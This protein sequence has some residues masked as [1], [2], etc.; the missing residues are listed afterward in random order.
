MQDVPQRKI[1]RY[2][3]QEELGRGAMGVVYRAQDP[4][5][6]RSIAI[7][8]IHVGQFYSQQEIKHVQ[9]RLMREAHAAGVLSHPNIVTIYDI[10][11]EPTTAFILME[12]VDGF[13]LDKLLTETANE[14]QWILSILRQS[15]EAL[16]CAHACG[17]VH[18]D[19]KPAN[20]MVTRD[21]R[22]KI[23]DFGVAR[24]Q[25]QALTQTGQILGTPEYM[26]PEQISGKAVDG[27]SDQFSL[28]V[29]AYEVLSGHKPFAAASLPAL[30]FRIV[31]A[32][33]EPVQQWNPSL[34][35]GIDNV[36][37]C[38]LAKTPDSRFATCKDFIL[39]LECELQRAPGWTIGPSAILHSNSKSNTD[40]PRPP[41][42]GFPSIEE[43]RHS[44]GPPHM[45]S[46]LNLKMIVTV[47]IF[48]ALLGGSAVIWKVRQGRVA[49]IQTR[50]LDNQPSGPRRPV[51]SDGGNPE[52]ARAL[53]P[54]DP[55]ISP[56]SLSLKQSQPRLKATGEWADQSAVPASAISVVSN[57]RGATVIIDDGKGT[58]CSTP[59]LVE[60]PYGRHTIAVSL[61]TYK[62]EYRVLELPRDSAVNISLEK[63]TGVLEVTSMPTAATVFIDGSEQGATTP[64]RLMVPIGKH[65]ITVSLPGRT[66][67]VQSIEIRPGA[68]LSLHPQW[69]Q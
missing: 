34:T 42:V 3:I 38:A 24:I 23:A 58:P 66:A 60:L 33:P 36:L 64:T 63:L 39:A 67:Y 13:C 40:T 19:I 56:V 49:L 9:A 68:T 51:Q 46:A 12:F 5:L 27:R 8:A 6:G 17:V 16:D 55:A 44:T 22:A 50:A 54:Q 25:S 32:Q 15:A 26:S 21:G 69:E 18:R 37:R 20:I 1:G 57:P 31:T 52:A 41:A 53:P 61:D 48:M 4:T 2:V 35:P 47:G 45:A 65:T 43:E 11:Q 30:I 62:P 29:I 28:A 14:K 59:C 7:K 10:L